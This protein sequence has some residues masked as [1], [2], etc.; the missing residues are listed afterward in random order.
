MDLL[1]AFLCLLGVTCVC[2]VGVVLFVDSAA[3][4]AAARLKARVEARA[5][6]AE[7]YAAALARIERE[8]GM[9][10]ADNG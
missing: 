9:E 2:I 8:F 10:A 3:L 4:W 7:R 6:Y 5:A 1:A